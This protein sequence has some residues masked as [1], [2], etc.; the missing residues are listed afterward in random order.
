MGWLIA[1]GVIA[2][3]CACAGLGAWVA[4][5]KRRPAAQGVILGFLFGPIGVLILAL[6]PNGERE[7]PSPRPTVRGRSLDWGMPDDWSPEAEER[8]MREERAR[9]QA[10][11]R[12]DERALRFLNGDGE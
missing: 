9:G 4:G 2:T 6:L 8:R 5:E 12:D 7:T 3:W 10:K 1:A 11:E